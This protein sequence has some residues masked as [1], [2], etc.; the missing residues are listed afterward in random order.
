MMRNEDVLV[1]CVGHLCHLTKTKLFQV[2]NMLVSQCYSNFITIHAFLRVNYDANTLL[3]NLLFSWHLCYQLYIGALISS[4]RCNHSK[5]HTVHLPGVSHCFCLSLA[6]PSVLEL[7]LSIQPQNQF[8][9]SYFDRD[10]FT[11]GLGVMVSH[12]ITQSYGLLQ[13][14]TKRR[15]NGS[16]L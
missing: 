6:Y 4:Y 7:C 16:F 15:N 9:I 14:W 3:K 2:E 13:E 5:K 12:G 11:C 1:L 10:Y 8:L